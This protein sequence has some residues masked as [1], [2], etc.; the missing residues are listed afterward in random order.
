MQLDTD[1]RAR[2]AKVIDSAREAEESQARAAKPAGTPRRP[3]VTQGR[4]KLIRDM[5]FERFDAAEAQRRFD[6]FE[7]EK[8]SKARFDE[9]YTWLRQVPRI[10]GQ[11]APVQAPV[12]QTTT[13]LIEGKFTVVFA[14]GGHKTL[15]VRR[16]REDSKF[17]P[18]ELLVGH[19]VGPDNE[20][21]YIN[22][23][24]VTPSGNV[25]IWRK[26]QGNERL[27]EAVR[28]LVGDPRAAAAAYAEASGSCCACGRTLTAPVEE[29]PFRAM[30]LG[31]ECG[32]R[33]GW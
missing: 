4:I 1:L 25:A 5:L 24:H 28:V 8:M 13:P 32:K 22:V 15:R 21:D 14:D 17:K 26:H 31:P 12:I 6:Y 30:G 3:Y 20:S 2:F 23:G 27:A 7:W 16:Q 19:L 9:I 33:S 18:G 11:A 29:N 10:D